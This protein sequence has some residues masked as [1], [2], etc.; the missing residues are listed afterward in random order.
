MNIPILY[1]HDHSQETAGHLIVDQEQGCLVIEL[2]K[3]L[4]VQQLVDAEIGYIPTKV[5]FDG[6]GNEII[7]EAVLVKL[8]IKARDESRPYIKA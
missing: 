7:T 3:G 8:S 1:G 2:K 6:D 4:T 5:E